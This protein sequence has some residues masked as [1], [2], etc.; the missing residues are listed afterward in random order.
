MVVLASTIGHLRRTHPEYPSAP[1]GPPVPNGLRS[2]PMLTAAQAAERVAWGDAY[3]V[4]VPPHGQA[5]PPARTPRRSRRGQEARR[6][7]LDVEPGLDGVARERDCLLTITR[8]A[9]GHPAGAPSGIGT[10]V[11]AVPE[12]GEFDVDRARTVVDRVAD[13]PEG[14]AGCQPPRRTSCAT[15]LACPICAAHPCAVST[16]PGEWPPSSGSRWRSRRPART[17]STRA[18]SAAYRP[19]SIPTTTLPRPL[20]GPLVPRLHHR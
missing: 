19:S 13:G 20:F 15:P 14:G 16:R 4:R 12:L 9:L 17:S 7:V 18:T 2:S 6:W 10:S 1:D 8:S 11:S 5:P 3:A